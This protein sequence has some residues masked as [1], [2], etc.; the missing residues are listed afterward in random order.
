M[1][2]MHSIAQRPGGEEQFRPEQLTK[3]A[4]ETYIAYLDTQGY[5][6]RS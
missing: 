2:L 5:G 3:T 4:R 1:A 6:L